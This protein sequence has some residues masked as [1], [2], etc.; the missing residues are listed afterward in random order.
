MNASE[1]QRKS[2]ILYI[3]TKS[4]WGGAQRYVFDLSLNS[5]DKFEV[6]VA[7]GG[8]GPLKKRLEKEGVRVIKIK[9]MERDVSARKEFL[10]F[11]D[12]L[13]VIVREKPDV[14]HLNSSKAGGL[15][16]LASRVSN[17]FRK[18]NSKIIFTAHG[19]PF[20]EERAKWQKVLIKFLS[21]LNIILSHKTI[22]ISNK[23]YKDA[24]KM[25]LTSKKVV[26][27]Y[28]GIGSIDFL[29][30][31]SATNKLFEYISK[32][33]PE[34]L[35]LVGSI[36]ELHKNKGYEYLIKSFKEVARVRSDA[37][38][39]IIGEGEQRQY[40]EKLSESLG[41]MEKICLAGTVP[42]AFLY[43]KA[44]DIYVLSSIKEGLPYVL[45]EAGGA[46]IPIISTNVGGVPEL[47]ED[48]HSGMII[49]RKD[50]K[51]LSRAILYLMDNSEKMELFSK[52][53]KSNI[54]KN[55][56]IER[57]LKETFALYRQS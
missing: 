26:L 24:L 39:V 19:W 30:K 1:K 33:K 57:M 54:D 53:T 47:M 34:K 40:L 27:I 17:F 35:F 5:K 2:K 55:F 46:E 52:N 12:I 11:F 48:M 32:P 38:L 44:F 29:D 15:G 28:N 23:D 16:A 10:S 56:S 49:R 6:V 45:L 31:D 25:P 51:E 36:G 14:I 43:L 18:T 8:E 20:N 9:K 21:W 41:L 37:R 22:V 50:E 13:S 3:I 42:E 4:N 7:L